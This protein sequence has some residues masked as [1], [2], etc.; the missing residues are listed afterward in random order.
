MLC[1]S[2]ALAD[3]LKPALLLLFTRAGRSVVYSLHTTRPESRFSVSSLHVVSTLRCEY[4]YVYNPPHLLACA[5]GTNQLNKS[6][7]TMFRT[8]E[9]W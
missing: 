2:G 1:F 9:R 6:V 4:L 7:G 8:I 5:F 3:L